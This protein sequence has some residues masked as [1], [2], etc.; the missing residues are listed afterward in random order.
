MPQ[1]RFP[2]PRQARKLARGLGWFSIGLGL[3]ELLAARRVAHA[4]GLP[5]QAALVA[6]CGVRALATGL[7]L[8]RSAQPADW[9]WGRVA[10]DALDAVALATALQG[11]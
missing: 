1:N 7:G 6:V 4:V 11:R 9:L 2:S 10:G 5:G 3:V 8:L